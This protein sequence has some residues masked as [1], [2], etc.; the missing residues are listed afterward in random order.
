MKIYICFGGCVLL[1]VFWI[2]SVLLLKRIGS[3]GLSRVFDFF[4]TIA[5]IGMFA[6]GAYFYISQQHTVRAEMQIPEDGLGKIP[7]TA[8]GQTGQGQDIASPA[9]EILPN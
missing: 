6:L 5:V 2:V 4:I 8:G 1:S 7:G 9:Q 3:W